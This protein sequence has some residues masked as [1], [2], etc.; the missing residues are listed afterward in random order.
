MAREL[1]KIYEPQNVESRIY[2]MW[3]EGGYFHAEA[4]ALTKALLG[5]VLLGIFLFLPAWT[6]AYFHA[7]LFLG[8][9]FVPMLLVGIVLFTKAPALLEKRLNH[10]EKEMKW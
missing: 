1:P 10:K 5:F 4:D 2:Q 7:W 8:L 6:L 3:Q 9:L